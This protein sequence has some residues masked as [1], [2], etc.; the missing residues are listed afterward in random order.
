MSSHANCSLFYSFNL[1][2]QLSWAPTAAALAGG[3]RFGKLESA[4]VCKLV[5]WKFFAVVVWPNDRYALC[6][7]DQQAV[8]HTQPLTV[9]CPSSCYRQWDQRVTLY[10]C[11]CICKALYDRDR[12]QLALC[13]VIC[14]HASR[15]TMHLEF[16]CGTY[17]QQLT[18]S[19]CGNGR[20]S[21]RPDSAQLPALST[22]GDHHRRWGHQSLC[23]STAGDSLTHIMW[24]SSAETI[25]DL[26]LLS[27]VG[28]GKVGGK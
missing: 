1:S 23:V 24:R 5:I 11:T 16:F 7:R 21:S 4:K 25:Q 28:G 3:K 13:H 27:D 6:R 8:A 17:M 14:K 26:I 18:D 22:D 2:S 10:A 19:Q 9:L 12:C 15:L 20:V